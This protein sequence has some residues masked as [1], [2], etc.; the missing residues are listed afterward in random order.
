MDAGLVHLV[1]DVEHFRAALRR[2]LVPLAVEVDAGGIGAQVAAL[3]PVR[4]HV[5]NDVEGGLLA[6]TPGDGVGIVEQLLERAFHPPFGHRL[7]RMLTRVEP[8]LQRPGADLEIIQFLSV[9]RLSER[10]MLDRGM[11]GDRC[12]EIVVALHRVGREISEPDAVRRGRRADRQHAVLVGGVDPLPII[13]VVAH[14][15]AVAGPAMRIGRFLAIEDA[16][17]DRLA[18]GTHQPEIE[19][20]IE[21][22]AVVLDDLEVDTVAF[23]RCDAN[24]A[25]VEGGRNGET[26]RALIVRPDSPGKS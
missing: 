23:D 18:G 10:A 4:I 25:A 8:D 9:Q 12:D 14:A 11:R 13:A 15:G 7:T 26:H 2:R 24:V 3:R 6:Q 1:T 20:L 19:P 16:Q 21:I 17:L 5:R 22:G